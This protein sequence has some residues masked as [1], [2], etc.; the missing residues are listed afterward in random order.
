MKEIILTF[1][2]DGT[3]TKETKGFTG[4]SCVKETEFIEKA[5]GAK[6]G[7]RRF[8]SEYYEQEVEQKQRLKV[9]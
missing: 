3:V 7:K 2:S 5:L 9:R 6:P 8:K 4:K 1:N